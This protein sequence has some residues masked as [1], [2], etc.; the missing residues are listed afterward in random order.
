MGNVKCFDVVSMVV[1]EANQQFRPF[2]VANEEKKLILKQYCGIIDSLAN[3][4]DGESFEVEIDEINMEIQVTLECG[5]MI[6]D[7]PS[8]VFYELTKRAMRIGFSATSDDKIHIKFVF[9]SIWDKA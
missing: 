2:W 6:I 7:S 4:F 9:P 3:D 5:E 8:H 1:E